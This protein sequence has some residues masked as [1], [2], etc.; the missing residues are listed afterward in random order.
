MLKIFLSLFFLQTVN[1]FYKTPLIKR[2]QLRMT[3][4]EYF[5]P[6]KIIT[7]INRQG[8]G[9]TWTYSKLIEEVKGHHV[10]GISFINE[11]NIAV[12]IDNLSPDG[13]YHEGNIHYTKLLP[14]TYELLLKILT[15]NKV[16]FD[17]INKSVENNGI[18]NMLSQAFFTIGIYSLIVFGINR[19]IRMNPNIRNNIGGKNNAN[20]MMNYGNLF[21]DQGDKI[22]PT[23]T[24]GFDDVAGCDEAKFEL[25][26]TVDFLKNPAIYK[27]AGA[28][29]PKGILLEGPPG[30]GKTLLA[31][32]VAGE[33][34]VPF[35][36]AS[37]SEFIEMFVGVG[38]SRVRSLFDKAAELA[39]CVIFIDEIDA[40]GRKRGAG[41]AG[42]N[43]EREQTL[44]EI[45]TRMDGFDTIDG[46]IVIGATN[47]IDILDSALV[48]PGRFDRKVTVSL[49]DYDGRVAISKVH[50]KNKKLHDDFDF[51]ELAALTGGF[52][53]ADLANLANEA[54]ILSVRKNETNINADTLLDAYEK[55]TLGLKSYNQEPNE[56]VTELISYHETGHGLLVLLFKEFFELRK[57]TIDANKSGAGGYTLFTP[58][59]FY[60][61]Y[62]TKGFCL[63]Q[64]AISLGGRAAEVYLS[65]KNYNPETTSNQIFED[66]TDLSVT[67]GA[68]NDLEQAYNLAKLYITRFGFSENFKIEIKDRTLPF[69]GEE[70]SK[71]NKNQGCPSINSE[72]NYLLQYSFEIAFDLIN[73][74]EEQ[75]LEIIDLLKEKRTISIKDIKEIE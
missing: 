27:E 31:K 48:R 19:L 58:N 53:G 35:L 14:D 6:F 72:I 12:S 54:A 5:E 56:K 70:L 73:K 9:D 62:P 69:L 26:E 45:L 17:V 52:S 46:I 1:G 61:K 39:P 33:A 24:V 44:N 28:K 66:Y 37:G 30:T 50:F 13:I 16:S 2:M 43:D 8:V 23:L 47:R 68:T 55:I 51:N 75:F 29:I 20:D 25:T 49:P 11:G 63:A 38:A 71:N 57:I 3:T 34:E 59:D 32:A 22:V 10:D 40:V 15:D 74:N 36:S 67:T 21:R 60:S 4:D 65:R 64:L 7:N 41:I 18:L 42:G